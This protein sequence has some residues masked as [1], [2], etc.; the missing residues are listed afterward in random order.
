MRKRVYT[1]PKVATFAQV[2][3]P[4][5][6]AGSGEGE[7]YGIDV[8]NVEVVPGNGSGAIEGNP[9]QIDAKDNTGNSW[10]W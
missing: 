2:P 5:L 4:C 7:K 3:Q 1:K 9:D 6:L 8:D 10:D